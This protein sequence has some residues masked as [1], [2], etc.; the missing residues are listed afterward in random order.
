MWAQITMS[1]GESRVCVRKQAVLILPA[2]AAEL[3]APFCRLWSSQ[4]S[5]SL[6]RTLQAV[7]WAG[8]H[9]L[10]CPVVM[11]KKGVHEK[12]CEGFTGRIVRF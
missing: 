5:Y 4:H 2:L 12:D 9:R 3:S 1:H 11:E 7:C 8:L 10:E 6:E